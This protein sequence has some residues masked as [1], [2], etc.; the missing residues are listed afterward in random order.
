MQISNKTELETRRLQN[1]FLLATDGWQAPELKV[2]VRYSQGAIYSGTFASPPSRI[3]VNLG[4][5][6]QYPMKIETGIAKA[7]NCGLSWWKPSY[8]IE[9]ENEY[10]LALF[11]FLHEFYHYLIHQASRN[12]LRKEAMCDRFAVRYLNEHCRLTVYDVNHQPVPES[13]WLFQDLDGFVRNRQTVLIPT[14][15]AS[16]PKPPKD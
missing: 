6:N 16:R 10:Q 15:A 14:R 13:A 1:M 11:V 12:G 5:E 9:V 3:F 4:R 8:Y 2:S 7:W